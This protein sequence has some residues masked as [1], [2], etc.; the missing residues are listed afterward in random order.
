[1]LFRSKVAVDGVDKN[2][3]LVGNTGAIATVVPFY[4]KSGGLNTTATNFTF[5]ANPDDYVFTNFY[6]NNGSTI[7]QSARAQFYF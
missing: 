3:A 2:I 1:M 4:T 6:F 7:T 5:G